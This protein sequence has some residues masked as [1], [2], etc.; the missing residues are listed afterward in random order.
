MALFCNQSTEKVSWL[1]HSLG[2]LASHQ[3]LSFS[4]LKARLSSTATGALLHGQLRSP[5]SRLSVHH[6]CTVCAA[7]VLPHLGRCSTDLPISKYKRPHQTFSNTQHAKSLKA[8][9]PG[10][11]LVEEFSQGRKQLRLAAHWLFQHKP[12][13]KP[14]YVVQQERDTSCH[15][16][17][18]SDKRSGSIP[19]RE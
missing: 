5:S 14:N 19:S 16:V 7:S 11:E 12:M 9:S 4:W 17:S 1:A 8:V 6:C 15:K 13:P 10:L 18:I 2:T 3:G